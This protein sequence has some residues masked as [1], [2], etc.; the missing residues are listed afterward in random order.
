VPNTEKLAVRTQN[1]VAGQVQIISKIQDLT[2]YLFCSVEIT[3]SLAVDQIKTM[4]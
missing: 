4:R 3:F 2:Q 1:N